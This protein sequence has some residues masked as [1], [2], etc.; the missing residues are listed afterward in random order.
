MQNLR[1][2][3]KALPASAAVRCLLLLSM[4]FCTT[5]AT[6][7]RTI[8][9]PF[10]PWA[11]PAPEVLAAGSSLDQVIAAVNQ[12]SA[13]IT[14]FQTNNASITVPGMPAIPLLKGN[15]AAQRPGRVRLQASTL[16]GPEVDL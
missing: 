10:A 8:R 15:I 14:S 11:P 6:C 2:E 16:M 7:T 3:V 1:S 9:S 13:K 12:N 5:G 4:V